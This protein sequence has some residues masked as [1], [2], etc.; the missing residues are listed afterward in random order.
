MGNSRQTSEF[1]R[2]RFLWLDQ[3]LID[4]ELPASAFKVAYRISDGFN[5]QQSDGRAWESCE[6]IAAA[7][8]MSK[9]HVIR[10]VKCLHASGHLRV[11]WG[12]QGRGHPN[13]YWLILK[14]AST[15]LSDEIKGQPADLSDEIKGTPAYLFDD[16]IKGTSTP[17]KGTSASIK[18]TSASIQKHFGKD[19]DPHTRV[20]SRDAHDEHHGAAGFRR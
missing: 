16:K 4:P 10:M 18:G 6:S 1:K 11:E 2:Q 5:D 3:V 12:Q 8:G 13:Q 15:H 7:T 14:G 19:G 20:A 9:T 17:R